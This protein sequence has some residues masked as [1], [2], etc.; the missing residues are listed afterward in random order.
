MKINDFGQDLVKI[1][2]FGVPETRKIAKWAMLEHPKHP[3][4]QK[5]CGK[6]SIGIIFL[7]RK[8]MIFLTN[9]QIFSAPQDSEFQDLTRSPMCTYLHCAVLSDFRYFWKYRCG[10][11]AA[12]RPNPFRHRKCRDLR[13]NIFCFF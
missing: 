2:D 11:R 3:Q 10:A 5:L 13:A 9:F 12:D 4:T 6:R 1:Y 7:S 8:K